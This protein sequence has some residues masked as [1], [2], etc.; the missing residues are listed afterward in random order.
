MSAYICSTDH[1]AYLAAAALHPRLNP[2]SGS[3]R[4]HHKDPLKRGSVGAGDFEKAVE[5]ANVLMLE[6]VR[7]VSHRYPGQKSSAGLPGEGA[8]APITK[9]QV[10][11]WVFIAPEPVEIL[12]SIACLSYQ[13]CEHPEWEQSEA[14]AFLDALEGAAIAALVGYEQAPWGCP[15]RKPKAKR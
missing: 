3:F 13:S 9:Q 11:E 2:Y 4:W 12:K 1:F 7:S 5:I 8:G 14:K 10:A 15:D 6:N